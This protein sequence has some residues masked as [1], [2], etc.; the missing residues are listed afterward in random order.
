[1]TA[2]HEVAALAIVGIDAA[3]YAGSFSQWSNLDL[4]V[5]TGP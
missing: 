4:P 3:L 1:V 2:A 5:D